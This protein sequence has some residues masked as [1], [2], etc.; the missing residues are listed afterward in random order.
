[1]SLNSL[2][3]L[4]PSAWPGARVGLPEPPQVEVIHAEDGAD[5]AAGAEQAAAEAVDAPMAL[6]GIAESEAGGADA[7][8]DADAANVPHAE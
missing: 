2:P 8:A 6:P 1:V 7:D 4:P 5:A 3:P